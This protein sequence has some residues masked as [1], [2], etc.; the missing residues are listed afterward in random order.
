MISYANNSVFIIVIISIC[1]LVNFIG[2][3]TAFSAVARSATGEDWY[4]IMWDAAVRKSVLIIIIS[5]SV[6][7]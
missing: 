4:Q 5:F 1:R 3:S 6:I 2:T 7:K